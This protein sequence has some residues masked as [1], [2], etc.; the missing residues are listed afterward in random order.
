MTSSDLNLTLM[1]K[2]E[3]LPSILSHL[4]LLAFPL[5][6][7]HWA[8]KER[9]HRSSCCPGIEQESLHFHL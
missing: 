4:F 5:G 9:Y 8:E 1:G 2:F 7:E 6:S 3:K